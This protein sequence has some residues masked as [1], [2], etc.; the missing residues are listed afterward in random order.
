V[1]I[2]IHTHSP[3]TPG[4]SLPLAELVQAVKAAGLDGFCL[5]DLHSVAGA[6][7]ARALAAA[8]GLLALVGFEAHTDRG[9]YLAF[10]PEPEKLPALGNWLRFDERGLASFASL[11]GAVRE[12]GGALVALRP[13]DRDVPG[14]PGDK[15]AQLEGIAA[16]LVRSSRRTDLADDMAEELTAGLGLPGVA[17]SGAA[18]SAEGV[19]QVASLLCGPLAREADLVE[20]LRKLN[21][22]PV[23][24][25]REERP[26]EDARRERPRDGDRG[27]DRPRGDGDRDRGRERPRGRRDDRP[28]RRREPG[29]GGPPREGARP[30]RPP[31]PEGEARPAGEGGDAPAKRRR[32]RRRKPGEGGGGNPPSA[33]PTD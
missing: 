27:R 12:R 10:L 4:A 25:G 13:Y 11:Q 5:T 30:P 2:D 3:L 18:T 28:P 14:A 22:W 17:G 8:A 7:E 16:V 23:T 33:G 9:R 31:R 15:L 32:R 20:Q 6:A 24:I 26:R 1:L 29:E 19:G 21:A